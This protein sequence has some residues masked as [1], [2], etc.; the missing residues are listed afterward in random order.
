MK[1]PGSRELFLPAA[2]CH[3]P[4]IHLLLGGM[5]KQVAAFKGRSQWLA[6]LIKSERLIRY[7]GR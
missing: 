3:R 4:I 5:R 2:Q 1:D 6:V 7:K